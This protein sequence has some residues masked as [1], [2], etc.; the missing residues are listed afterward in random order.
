MKPEL[1]AAVFVILSC[2]F[3]SMAD[4]LSVIGPPAKGEKPREML[5]D[6]L[7]RCV[8]EALDR[9]LVELEKLKTREQ[10]E[11]YQKRLRSKFIESLGGFPEK[12]PLRART[13]GGLKG[14]GYRTEKVIYESRP[15]FHVT[16]I[17]YL[18]ETKPPYPGVLL[19]C[20]HS[21]NGKA[22][23]AYQRASI[24]LAKN[25]IAVLCYDPIGQG[26][27]KQLLEKDEA[28]RWLPKGRF[29]ATGEHMLEGVAPIPLGQS[30]ATYR[31]WDGIRSIDYLTSRPEIDASRI[32]CTGNSGGGLMTSYLM[33]L[34]DRIVAAAPGCFITTTRRKNEKP[35]PGDAE[36]NIFGQIAYGMDHPDYIIMH[37][38]KPTL[39]CAATRDFV[40]IEGT[41]EA[42]RQ[43]KRIYAR[44]GYAER[45][46][47]IE[48]PDRH[49]FSRPLRVGM[50]RWMRRWL[51]DVDDAVTEADFPVHTDQEL[52]CTPDGQVLLMEGAKPIFQLYVDEMERAAEQRAQL[53]KKLS[54]EELVNRIRQVVGVRPLSKIPL[55]EVTRA[56][57]IERDDCKIEKLILR[58][59]EGIVLPALYFEPDGAYDFPVLYVNSAG[60]DA[61]QAADG[62]MT[63]GDFRR[64]GAAALAVDL[65]GYGE[66]EMKSWRYGAMADY[67]GN[68]AAEYFVA[69][70]L[71][72][73]LVGMRAEDLIVCARYLASRTGKGKVRLVA[74]GDVIEPAAHAVALAPEL[75]A[76]YRLNG[77]GSRPRKAVPYTTA[78]L[79][80]AV[81]GALRVYDIDDLMRLCHERTAAFRVDH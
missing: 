41:W 33:A 14:E 62:S 6:Y 48:A 35:G 44:L 50:V 4:D 28:G 55:T 36:Q 37:A 11:S 43:A 17:L 66:T 13:V 31:I 26:E 75:F 45:V 40:P 63:G 2:A 79:E 5:R 67:V 1:S 10:I 30:L 60:K 56:V 74:M 64:A 72:G 49:G 29:G 7:R 80:N 53:Q 81:H 59:E 8:H 25:G 57:R 78:F 3:P 22:A 18:P 71:S 73:S 19:P 20:G 34:D 70:M 69:Y 77:T 46:D 52:Q 32:G 68:N 54:T 23:G 38:P 24:L 12:T 15:G 47:L 39:I 61:I 51:L 42:F 9:R 27:R 21:A 58:P 65:R 76:S 16:A